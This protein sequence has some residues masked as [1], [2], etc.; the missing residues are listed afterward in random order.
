[1]ITHDKNNSNRSKLKKLEQNPNPKDT[2]QAKISKK[3]ETR[4]ITD[5]GPR[6]SGWGFRTKKDKETVAAIIKENNQKE[7]KK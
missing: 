2:R 4:N 1:M 5:Y 6:L 3:A 7:Q